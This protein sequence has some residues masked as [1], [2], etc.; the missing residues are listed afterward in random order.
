MATST[1]RQTATFTRTP[2]VAGTKPR[3][4]LNPPQATREPTLLL[5]AAMEDRKGLA[6]HRHM[7]EAAVVGNHGRRA[8]V[9][10]QAA[11]VAAGSGSSIRLRGRM[12]FLTAVLA[13]M[14][15][16]SSRFAMR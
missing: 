5:L 6:G 3:E 13:G 10:R 4:L 14:N 11:V 8:L 16:Q 7:A 12:R 1:Q 2:G 15:W 9:V